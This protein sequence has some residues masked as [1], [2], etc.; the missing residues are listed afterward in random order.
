MRLADSSTANAENINPQSYDAKSLAAAIEKHFSSAVSPSAN[1]ESRFDLAFI[2]TQ[3][4]ALPSLAQFLFGDAG[5]SFGGLIVEER[6]EWIL[7]YVFLI[8]GE[9][10]I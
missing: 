10:W 5:C 3:P 8:H 7:R 2:L 9:S 6:E 4:E 1:E